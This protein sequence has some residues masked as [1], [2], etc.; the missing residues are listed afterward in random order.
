MRFECR[1]IEKY[2]GAD[3][4]SPS[5]LEKKVEEYLEADN[6]SQLGELPVQTPRTH[7]QCL[8]WR[9]QVHFLLHLFKDRRKDVKHNIKCSSFK[10]KY[11]TALNPISF[12]DFT[13]LS[14]SLWKG[15]VEVKIENKK[16]SVGE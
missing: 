6:S 13:S 9:W 10:T 14:I 4:L 2:L 7:S 16:I 1:H 3:I 15:V 8:L 12:S 11:L 5:S